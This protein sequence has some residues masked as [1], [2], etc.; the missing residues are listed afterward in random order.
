MKLLLLLFSILAFTSTTRAQEAWRESTISGIPTDVW[1]ISASK[2]T[3][4]ASSWNSMF[5]SSDGGSSWKRIVLEHETLPKE[6]IFVGKYKSDPNG[7]FYFY[8]DKSLYRLTYGSDTAQLLLSFDTY[9]FRSSSLSL[10]SD[11]KT[12]VLY[13]SQEIWVSHDYGAGWKQIELY[14]EE[15]LDLELQSVTY[16]EKYGIIKNYSPKMNLYSAETS[17]HV[18]YTNNDGLVWYQIDTIPGTSIPIEKSIEVVDSSL[19]IVDGNTYNF[20]TKRYNS[21]SDKKYRHFCKTPSGYVIATD[22]SL[23]YSDDDGDTWSQMKTK[24]FDEL[25]YGWVDA[26]YADS[27]GTLYA[28]SRYGII[29]KSTDNGLTWTSFPFT[30]SREQQFFVVK[31]TLNQVHAFDCWFNRYSSSDYGASWS[32]I[33]FSTQPDYVKE[34]DINSKGEIVYMT[35]KINYSP[36]NGITWSTLSTVIGSSSSPSNSKIVQIFDNSEI[37]FLGTRYSRRDK[38]FNKLDVHATNLTL[39]KNG[40]Y[41]SFNGANLYL[42]N[43]E[44]TTEEQ[45]DLSI[46]AKIGNY[47]TKKC[48]TVSNSQSVYVGTEKGLFKSP[49]ASDNFTLIAFPDQS[50]DQIFVD[51]NGYLYVRSGTA[52]YTSKNDGKSWLSINLNL[53]TESIQDIYAFGDCKIIAKSNAIYYIDLKDAKFLTLTDSILGKDLFFNDTLTY[54]CTVR[55]NNNLPVASAGVVLY[56]SITNSFDTVMTDSK[57]MAVRTISMSYYN[58]N[59]RQPMQFLSYAFKSGFYQSSIQTQNI[60]Y[61]SEKKNLRCTSPNYVIAAPGS[62]AGIPVALSIVPAPGVLF[63]KG[64]LYIRNEYK[65][66]TDTIPYDGIG[67]YT[68]A[69]DIAPNAKFGIY[70]LV[71]TGKNEQNELTTARAAYVII[72][73]S[74]QWYSSGN[75]DEVPSPLLVL[76]PNPASEFIVVDIPESVRTG[77][78]QNVLEIYS[79]DGARVLAYSPTSGTGSTS[80]R[81]DISGLPTGVYCIKINALRTAFIKQ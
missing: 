3:L 38:K 45:I 36:D 21:L 47:S 52:L 25:R 39:L 31:N 77:K 44:L 57:G 65:G 56:N 11:G 46:E 72:S 53:G 41:L 63:T 28:G 71:I 15:K 61:H 81:I 33:P 80:E 66:V 26:F 6:E 42:I 35:N 27:A 73:D 79:L 20:R 54:T 5:Q 17:Y 55:D 19:W 74:I 30:T 43:N 16:D 69:F 75:V 40:K 1:S 64:V 12:I 58:Q 70:K 29:K 78:G 7:T 68:Y 8:S 13:N 67:E 48:Y 34:Y 2:N 51:D 23:W 76:Y 14:D 22:S 59:L 37:I 10:S 24:I 18:F 62:Q 32:A 50:V 49:G 9:A 4:Y 60:T